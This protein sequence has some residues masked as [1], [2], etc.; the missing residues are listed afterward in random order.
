MQ[1]DPIWLAAPT[2]PVKQFCSFHTSIPT[3]W[4]QTDFKLGEPL[5]SQLQA[6]FRECLFTFFPYWCGFPDWGALWDWTIAMKSDRGKTN[7][8]YMYLF[9][10]LLIQHNTTINQHS[11]TLRWCGRALSKELLSNLQSICD[12]LYIY[13][14]IYI[15]ID[16]C[17]YPW[18][19]LRCFLLSHHINHHFRMM[20]LFFPGVWKANPSICCIN[21][22]SSTLIDRPGHSSSFHRPLR[23]LL[24][25]AGSVFVE[26][27][28]LPTVIFGMGK[29]AVEIHFKK[30]ESI[31]QIY[32]MLL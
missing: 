31:L 6:G 29:V 19:C 11:S 32:M 13:V 10:W 27:A 28:K 16:L 22:F 15:Y 7:G 12:I 1:H 5:A 26:D 17:W 21:L 8:I 24:W 4:L 30:N 9:E 14:Y 23:G 20:W 25:V 18:V 3:P 2:K